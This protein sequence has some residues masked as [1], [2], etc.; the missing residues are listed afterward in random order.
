MSRVLPDRPNLEHL[1]KQAK[2]RL[3]DLQRT[4]PVARLAD[5]QHAVARDYGFANWAA[6][7]AGVEAR[8]RP[9][10]LAGMWVADVA[11]SKRHPANQFQRAT[12]EVTIAG[13]LVTMSFAATDEQGR[14]ETGSHS[15]QT[16]G[17]EHAGQTGHAV[18]ARWIDPGTL[19]VEDRK[20]GV[21][22]GRGVYAVSADGRMLTVTSG[23]QVVVFNRPPGWGQT[24][25]TGVTGVRPHP[26]T[27]YADPTQ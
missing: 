21:V 27:P 9:N 8:Q 23:E 20:D 17:V 24:P 15:V 16:D 18:A 5:A 12:L 3:A 6:L 10:P 1:R 13:A 4:N 7:K 11:R 19:H 14:E 26:V 2:E 25:V 22:V